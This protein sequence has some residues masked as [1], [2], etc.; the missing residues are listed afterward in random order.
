MAK[1]KT[2]DF[3]LLEKEYKRFYARIPAIA[4]AKA[5]RFFKENFNRQAWVDRDRRERWKPRRH[6]DS[7]R[8][9][10]VKSGRL[11]RSIRVV[12]KGRGYVLV[13]TNVP[14]AQIHN[15]GGAIRKR[16]K[17]RAHKR[18]TRR[19]LQQVASHS[20]AMNVEIPKRQFIGESTNVIESVEKELLKH[21]ED[22]F[23]KI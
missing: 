3:R 8:A 20:R 21:L 6:K 10:L 1:N 11:K 17:V 16:V 23:M 13:G 9:I 22:I 7:G 12:A 15:E 4:G 5:V 18:N 19:G 14:Y 2:P